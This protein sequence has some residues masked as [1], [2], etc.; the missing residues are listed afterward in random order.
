MDYYN[1][2]SSVFDDTAWTIWQYHDPDTQSGIVMAFRRENSPFEEVKI[3]LKGILSDRVYSYL[4]LSDGSTQD[5]DG[6]V[7]IKLPEKRSSVIFE[8]KIK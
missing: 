2:G 1:H 8:Y 3:D 6:R 5:G 7:T 4:N